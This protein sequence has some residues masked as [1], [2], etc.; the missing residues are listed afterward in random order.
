M[1]S[2]PSQVLYVEDDP[3][4]T[5][6]MRGIVELRSA[7]QLR[8]A[9]SGAEARRR[10][11]EGPVDLVLCDLHLPDIEGSDLLA[12][13]RDAGL[14]MHVPAL[15][16]TAEPDRVAGELAARHGYRGHWCKPLDLAATLKDLD[17]WLGRPPAS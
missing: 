10:L 7:C 5:L 15:L 6:L 1:T 13:L 12:L 8:V 14:P 17:R 2:L 9:R 11:A 16:V 4:S 3:V